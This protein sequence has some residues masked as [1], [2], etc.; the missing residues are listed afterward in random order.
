MAAAV[1]VR[2]SLA[3]ARGPTPP[4]SVPALRWRHGV[5]RSAWI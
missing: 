2:P 3:A 5:P 4:A 1:A